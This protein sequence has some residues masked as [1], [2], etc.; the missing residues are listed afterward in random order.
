[1]YWTCGLSYFPPLQPQTIH[2]VNV[3]VDILID[4]YGYSS[5]IKVLQP[6]LLYRFFS[7]D[8]DITQYCNQWKAYKPFCGIHGSRRL[9]LFFRSFRAVFVRI[10]G[11]FQA[12]AL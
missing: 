8:G 4:I 11:T 2:M 1:M 6:A 10:S 7:L 5:G 3:S 9:K 12:V